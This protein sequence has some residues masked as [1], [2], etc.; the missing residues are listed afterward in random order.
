MVCFLAERPK[1]QHGT[2]HHS[3]E[4]AGLTHAE[5][6]ERF[7]DYLDSCPVDPQPHMDTGPQVLG[8]TYVRT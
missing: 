7:R 3:L 6:H 2:H 1:D 5:I 8:K 4:E